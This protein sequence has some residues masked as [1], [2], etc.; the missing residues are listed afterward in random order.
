[1]VR[2]GWSWRWPVQKSQWK[3]SLLVML[4]ALVW[5][6]IHWRNMRWDIT[7]THGRTDTHTVESSALF[8]LGRIRKKCILKRLHSCVAQGF[9]NLMK[10]KKA[11]S[12]QGHWPEDHKMQV[13]TGLHAAWIAIVKSHLSNSRHFQCFFFSGSISSIHGCFLSLSFGWPNGLSVS[14]TC[15]RV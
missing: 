1:M 3:T 12:P 8:C 4:S 5:S 9:L 14:F 7:P 15:I 13:P 6:G 10:S 2:D 11:V